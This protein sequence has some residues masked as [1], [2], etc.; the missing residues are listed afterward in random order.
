MKGL[1]MYEDNIALIAAAGSG[2]TTYIVDEVINNTTDRILLV[3]Y[4]SG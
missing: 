2:K 1:N 4:T 3:T